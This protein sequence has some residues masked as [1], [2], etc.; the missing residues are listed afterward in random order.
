M[1]SFEEVQRKSFLSRQSLQRYRNSQKQ[2][3]IF[4]DFEDKYEN[5]FV[6]LLIMNCDISWYIFEEFSSIPENSVVIMAYL[7]LQLFISWVQS[8]R[9]PNSEETENTQDSTSL[10][11]SRATSGRARGMSLYVRG[12]EIPSDSFRSSHLTTSDIFLKDLCILLCDM[13]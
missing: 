13:R 8:S 9:N 1:I 12:G 11:I 7:W 4:F 10:T 2:K 6:K 5:D 3:T